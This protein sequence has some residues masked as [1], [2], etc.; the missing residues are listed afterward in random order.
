MDT[1]DKVVKVNIR[2]EAANIPH[3]T[4][5]TIT[6]NGV[7][8]SSRPVMQIMDSMVMEATIKHAL[9]GAF[10]LKSRLKI[11]AFRNLKDF[12]FFLILK[13][14]NSNKIH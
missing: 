13:I 2:M 10:F 14:T 6:I 3:S 9:F 5:A 1:T 11:I 12:N 7:V 4:L 8:I